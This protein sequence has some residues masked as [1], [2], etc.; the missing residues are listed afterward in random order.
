MLPS[1]RPE[2]LPTSSRTRDTKIPLPPVPTWSTNP[3]RRTAAGVPKAAQAKPLPRQP[4]KH[5]TSRGTAP[6]P[7]EQQPVRARPDTHNPGLPFFRLADEE[8]ADLRR[9]SR[10]SAAYKFSDAFLARELKRLGRGRDGVAR[11]RE[12]ALQAGRLHDFQKRLEAELGEDRTGRN[13]ARGGHAA[14]RKMPLGERSPSLNAA[15]QGTPEGAARKAGVP[16]RPLN[17]R[18]NGLAADGTQTP[19]GNAVLGTSMVDGRMSNKGKAKELAGEAIRPVRQEM[20]ET[21]VIS[22]LSDQEDG[23]SA[24]QHTNRSPELGESISDAGDQPAHNGQPSDTGHRNCPPSSPMSRRRPRR[25]QKMPD[26][27]IP[28]AL[29]LFQELSPVRP[30]K[31]PRPPRPPRPPSPSPRDIYDKSQPRFFQ[32][33]CEWSGCQAMLNNLE[34]LRRHIGAAHGA[35]ARGKLRCR[36]GKCDGF[37]PSEP[38]HPVVFETVEALGDHVDAR[39]IESLAW[40]LGD[41]RIGQGLVVKDSASEYP[42]YLFWNGKQVTPSVQGQERETL[43]EW[44]AKKE[45]LKEVLGDLAMDSDEGSENSNDSDD[46]DMPSS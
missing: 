9:R 13:G 39:H 14:G 21:D 33:I 36:W 25:V 1:L 46:I 31:L 10:K 20:E 29:E 5:P 7:H 24:P 34:T 28:T 44:R 3:S 41:G 27:R 12:Q 11:A 2:S 6:P 4:P 43:A 19:N 22:L 42:A 30:A 32:F 23:A 8:L 17:Q 26:Y 37:E 18:D 15:G 45:M 35:E 38:A 40:H 16:F